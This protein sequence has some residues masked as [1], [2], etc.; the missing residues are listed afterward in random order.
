MGAH[1][2][3]KA[4]RQRLAFGRRRVARRLVVGDGER[5]AQERRIEGDDV[6]DA[7]AGGE[8]IADGELGVDAGERGV[9][10]RPVDQLGVTIAAEDPRA[11]A[12]RDQRQ[13]ARAAAD[14]PQRRR[15]RRQR[16]GDIERRDVERLRRRAGDDEAAPRQERRRAPAASRRRRRRDR[17]RPAPRAPRRSAPAAAPPPRTGSPATHSAIQPPSPRRGRSGGGRDEPGVGDA[18][19]RRTSAP[20]CPRRI[21][22]L[23]TRVK[24]A[25]ASLDVSLTQLVEADTF[26]PNMVFRSFAGSALLVCAL[27]FPAAARPTLDAGRLDELGRYQVLTFADPFRNGIE[28]GKAIGVIDATPEEVFRVATDYAKYRDF[29]PQRDRL[30]GQGSDARPRARRDAGRAALARRRVEG[31]RALHA[32]AAAGRD[33]P[34]ALRHASTARSSSTSARS[35]SSR[36]RR[37][38]PR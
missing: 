17:A 19:A 31:D 28:R 12:R 35:T 5:R 11:A 25:R 9:Q 34:R 32:R 20:R 29:M 37:A 36:S 38:R 8:Q 7:L 4:Q 22:Q 18:A 15:R 14:V 6:E 27:G 30:D 10:P 23:P 33:L 26:Y 16:R 2:V 24:S 21:Q 1:A 13:Q 3:E